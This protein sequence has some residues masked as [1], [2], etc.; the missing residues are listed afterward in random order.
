MN[1]TPARVL[2]VD[3]DPVTLTLL[4][5]VLSKEGYGVDTALG[6]EEAIARRSV[7]DHGQ[8]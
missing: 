5:E 2:V 1:K 4:N 6:G 3:D 8:L 7:R